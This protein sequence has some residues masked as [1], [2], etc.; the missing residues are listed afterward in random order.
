MRRGA[1]IGLGQA[2]L[3]GHLPGW[4]GR[5]D[6]EIVAVTDPRPT[7][8]AEAAARLPGARWHDSAEAL[9]ARE[10]VDFVDICTPPMS[11]ADLIAAALRRGCHVLCEKPLVC[12]PGELERVR[13]LAAGA[14][15]VLHTVHNWHHAPILRRASELVRDG[16]I[17]PVQR[18]VWETLRTR[19]AATGDPAR[20][21]WRVDPA[22]AGGGVLTDHGWH[23][24]YVLRRW[25]GEPLAVSATLE[26]RRHLGWPVEDTARIRLSFAEAAAE[27]LLTWAAEARRNRVELTGAQGSLSLEDDTIVLARAD[28]GPARRWHCPPAL[29][30]GSTHPDWFGPVADRFLAEV[31]GAAPPGDNLAEATACVLVEA[32]AR[33][34]KGR[35]LPVARGLA[36]A[37]RDPAA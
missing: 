28:G 16:A 8:R 22:V 26:R 24:I 10:A 29:S 1:I 12:S 19:P 3:H 9:L 15:R 18:V 35:M 7:Q 5:D 14:G 11:H 17:G 34:S 31:G 27:V 4:I 21:S 13:R 6:A 20:P 25:L 37:W 2:A 30:D 32:A 23:V 36:G 33:E